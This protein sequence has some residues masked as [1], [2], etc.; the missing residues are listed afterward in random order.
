MWYTVLQK[1]KKAVTSDI[2]FWLKQVFFQDRQVGNGG[3]EKHCFNYT[4]ISDILRIGL[5][6][7]ALSAYSTVL[8]TYSVLH[9]TL[10]KKNFDGNFIFW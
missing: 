6:I 3:T 2:H 7:T 5:F 4:A 10:M 8:Y 9:K 1:N